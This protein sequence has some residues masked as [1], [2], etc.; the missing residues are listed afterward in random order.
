MD[1]RDMT[2]FLFGH[3]PSN[4]EAVLEEAIR[5]D[6]FTCRRCS[7]VV[8]WS[9]MPKPVRAKV[10]LARNVLRRLDSA[11]PAAVSKSGRIRR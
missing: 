2:C 5:G 3:A 6:R 1:G 7:R 4:N 8:M 11:M 10:A 9:E